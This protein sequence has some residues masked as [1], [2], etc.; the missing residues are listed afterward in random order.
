MLKL[1]LVVYVLVAPVMMGVFLTA[2]LTMDLHRFDA[3]TIAAAAVAGA[4]V[5]IPVAWIVSRKI[6]TLR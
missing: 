5:A 2:L 1:P 6:A 4:L 3:T